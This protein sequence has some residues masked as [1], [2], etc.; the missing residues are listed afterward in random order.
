M[1]VQIFEDEESGG[2][3][4]QLKFLDGPKIDKIFGFKDSYGTIKI[5]RMSDCDIK[6]E[7]NGL[8]RCQCI[9]M[10][11]N[12]AWILKDGNGEKQSTNG[13]WLFVDDLFKIYD[14]M[15]FKAG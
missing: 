3:K 5:G 12:G 8:S 9:I 10:N 14:G 1:V 11:V 13:T 4:I 15:T 2:S 6:F 7:D